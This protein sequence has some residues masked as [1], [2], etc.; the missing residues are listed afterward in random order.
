MTTY[1]RIFNFLVRRV[2][3][4]AFAVGG[5]LIALDSVHAVL[6]GGTINFNGLPTSDLVLRWSA[7][8]VPLVVTA[9][10]VALYRVK[11]FT[12]SNSNG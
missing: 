6:P 2:V 1:W 5:I 8:V 7:I 4:M 12:P 11:P 10:G 9:L 3:A